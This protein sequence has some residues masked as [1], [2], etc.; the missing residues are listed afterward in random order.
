[1]KVMEIAERIR[2]TIQS[3]KVMLDGNSVSV[4]VSIGAST[5]LPTSGSISSEYDI[6]S[7]LVKIADAALYK[8]KREGRNRVEN[9][10]VVSEKPKV[11]KVGNR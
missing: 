3:H 7:K 11:D 6:P 8:A 4:T 5:F 10:G 9:G 2:K 1:M